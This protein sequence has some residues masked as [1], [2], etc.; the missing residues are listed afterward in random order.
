MRIH[1][2]KT[3]QQGLEIVKPLWERLRNH[4]ASVSRYFSEQIMKN[5]FEERSS[6]I[7]KKAEQG[8]IN[9]I[10]AKDEETD[11]FIGYCIGTISKANQGEVDS[12]YLLDQYRGN[13]IG[14][15]LMTRTLEW[16]REQGVEDIGISV[17]YGNESVLQFY[18]K[19]GFYPRLYVLKN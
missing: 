2:I 10:V 9:I 8:I 4:H 7:L 1:Y 15:V 3:D 18:E 16:F 5:T 13:G 11:E 6:N 19:Y 14:D 12:I 17:L